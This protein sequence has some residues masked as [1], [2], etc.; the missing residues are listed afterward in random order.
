MIDLILFVPIGLSFLISLFFLPSWIKKAKEMRLVWEDMNKNENVRVAGSGG[1]VV[2]LGFLV[3]VLSFIA[4]RT[5]Y[6]GTELNLIEILALFG[7]ILFLAA[8]GFIDD[9]MGW[10][11]GGLEKKHRLILV[12]I[13]SIPLI[14][15]NAGKSEIGLPFLGV[16]DVGLFYPLVLIPLGIVGA[17]TTF[18][19]LAGFNGLEAGQGALLLSGLGLVAMFTGN[20]W[21]GVISFCMVAALIGFLLFNFYPARVFPGDSL[22]YGVGGLIAI[23]AILGNFEK[24][25]VFFFIPYIIEVGLKLRGGLKIPS[26]GKPNNAGGLDLREKKF[27]SL[28]H[29]AIFVL[30]KFGKAT[31][32][33]VVYLIWAFQTAIILLGFLI[34]REGIFL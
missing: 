11:K 2:L 33:K 3:G 7:V 31:E 26:F 10:R 30:N 27:Y 12:A 34:F 28:N 20:T 6:L 14:V 17:A 22:T 13:A 16:F 32:K 4:Y 19:F 9:L 1:I 18:N 15:I 23:V 5:F 24:V 21:L 8:I 25:A 29:V